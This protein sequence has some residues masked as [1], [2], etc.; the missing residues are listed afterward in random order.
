M[1]STACPFVKG[2]LYALDIA[3]SEDGQEQTGAQFHPRRRPCIARERT[4]GWLAPTPTHHHILT[5][6]RS[7]GC[8]F[9]R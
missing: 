4:I 1:T 5:P 8:Q 3:E 6:C 2:L 7:Y 9:S